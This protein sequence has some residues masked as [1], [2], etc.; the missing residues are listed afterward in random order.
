MII[1]KSNIVSTNNILL[2]SGTLSDGAMVN[3]RDPDFSSNV[4]SNS[5]TFSIRFTSVGSIQYLGLHGLSLPVGCVVTI[6]GTGFNHSFTT[7]RDVKNL[8]FYQSSPATAG[9]L[10]IEFSGSGSKT[11]SYIQ[12]GL[13]TVIDWGTNPGQPLHYLASQRRTRA[14]TNENGMPVR[15]VQ[16]V[17][18]PRLRLTMNNMAKS[19]A[20]GDLQAL[21]E[22][23]ETY[24]I[25]SQLDYEN[26]SQPD[27]SCAL[28]ELSDF[29]VSTHS[30]TT[31][32][33]NVSLTCRALA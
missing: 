29:A 1:S 10:T 13:A 19:W 3:T 18:I 25:L 8:V 26:D 12:A 28:F 7:T 15:R 22:M 32:L 2:I 16:E 4:S 17:V 24:G 21:R 23:Y 9:N 20:R 31:E 33:V 5:T 11:V 14:T 30:Q 27:E 6:T